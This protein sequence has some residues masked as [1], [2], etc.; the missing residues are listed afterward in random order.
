MKRVFLVH[1]WGGTPNWFSWLKNELESNGFLVFVLDMPDPSYP[2][3]KEWVDFLRKEV[4]KVNGQ[5]YF[6]GHSIGC[7]TI[8]RYFESLRENEVV[9]GVIFVAGFFN[10]TGLDEE[11]MAI[12]KPWLETPIDFRKVKMRT[13]NFVAIQ[14]DNDPY[15]PVTDA[16]LFKQKLN[17]KVILEKGMGHFSDLDR[18][19][20]VVQEIMRF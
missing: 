12:A 14:S 18:F 8:M 4:G 15:V 1:G 20:K 13:F 10:L 17:A 5:T 11:D 19:P 9:G 7:Q 6:V 2:K 3:M 16:E